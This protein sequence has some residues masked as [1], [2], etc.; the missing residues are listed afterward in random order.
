MKLSKLL[1][2]LQETLLHLLLA[3]VITASVMTFP[4]DF[5]EAPLY[6]LRQN[7]SFKPEI[8]PRIAIVT[9]DDQTL[10]QLNE[11]SPLSIASHLKAVEQLEAQGVKAV[12]YVLDFNKVQRL[13]PTSF[14]SEAIQDFYRSTVRLNASGIPFMLGIPFDVNGEVT[15]PYPLNQIPQA[16][17]VVNRDG[18][19]FGKDKVTRRALVSIYD[20]PSFE[21]ALANKA[22][23]NDTI[24]PPPGTYKSSD[25][26]IQY[27]ML[28][29]HQHDGVVYDNNYETFSYPRY[30]FVDLVEGKLPPGTLKDKIVLVGS[31]QRENPNDFTLINSM[32]ATNKNSGMHD[33]LTPK[34]LVQA[35]ILD[36]ILNHQGIAEVDSAL[37]ALYCFLLSLLIIIASFRVRP[38]KLIAFTVYLIVGTFALSVL[39]FQPIPILGNHWLQLGAPLLSLTLSFY[40]MIPLRLYSEHRKRY[41]LEK[42]NKV[43]IEVEEMKTNFLQLVTHDLKTPVAKIQG[44]TESLKRSLNEKLTVKDNELMNHI[45][46]ANEDLNHFITSLLELTKL[47]NQGVRVYLQT[48]DINQLLENIVIKHRFAAQAKQIQVIT[49]FETLFPLKFDSELMSKVLSNLIDNGIKYSPVGTVLTIKTR[50]V[51]ASESG[52]K[53]DQ[54]EI[55]IRDQG[56]GIAAEELQNLFS[57]FYRIKND[58]TY[59]VKG[60]GLG[61]YLSKYFIEAHKGSI[62][63]ESEPGQGTQFTIRLPMD[64]SDAD[65]VQPGLRTENF[66]KLSKKEKSH[67]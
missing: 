14:N 61:L 67:A 12:G 38:S 7:L 23:A 24:A 43:L 65:I 36:S 32:S 56:V 35:N 30:S 42:Q 37:V 49:E 66:K 48:K 26:D 39:L 50:E 10:N 47:D 41:E 63:V 62:D 53:G 64:L 57:R 34:I 15:A 9:I 31:F 27:F 13:D 29:F 60:T 22:Y 11:L 46:S 59:N 44:L 54:I 58:A 16:V 19:V 28:R 52:G 1:P 3:A 40:L 4:L 5:L 8:D 33:G 25:T 20:Q 2:K 45:F 55:L 51:S 18:S 21:M 6:D 17:A